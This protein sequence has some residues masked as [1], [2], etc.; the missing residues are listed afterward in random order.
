MT[1]TTAT[2]IDSFAAADRP[3]VIV[4]FDG[5][6]SRIVDDPATATPVPGAVDALSGLAANGCQVVVLSGRPVEFLT[7]ALVGIDSR[8][9]MVGHS[10]LE[11]MENGAVEIDE[12]VVDWVPVAR[13]TL[14]AA[15]AAIPAG[16]TLED[17]GL[18][19]ALHYR[20][21]PELHPAA[22][23][24]AARLAADSGL[25]MKPGRM[26]VEL[27]PP[28]AVDKG[29]AVRRWLDD[30]ADVVL[31]AGDDLVDLPAFNTVHQ[32]PIEGVCVAVGSDEMP[33]E[34]AEAADLTV[35]SPAELVNLL[36]SLRR[37]AGA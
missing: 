23:E 27:R 30:L 36:T 11:M 5:T 24:V 9:Q 13:R 14:K 34:I 35:A 22:T 10:G 6:L 3:A 16:V 32:L 20:T 15:E 2:L 25:S 28:V 31:F 18:S 8:V 17:K 7:G 33:H 1:T 37:S 4:D 12:T 26:Y 21:S 29:T 19:F